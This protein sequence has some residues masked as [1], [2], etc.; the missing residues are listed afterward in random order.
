[1][2]LDYMI[3]GES[4]SSD[5]TVAHLESLLK[6]V[7]NILAQQVKVYGKGINFFFFIALNMK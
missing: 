4:A 5:S 3:Q 6:P 2:D 1:M 7:S